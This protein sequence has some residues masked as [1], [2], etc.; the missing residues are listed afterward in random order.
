ME[1][2]VEQGDGEVDHWIAQGPALEILLDAFADRRDVVPRHGAADDL[3]VELEAGAARLRL[4]LDLHIG[5]L[6]VPA[7]LALVARMLL[8]ALA[9]RLLERHLGLTAGHLQRIGAR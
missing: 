7:R 3:V 5:E 1:S 2:A 6:A 4:D 8:G 9:D